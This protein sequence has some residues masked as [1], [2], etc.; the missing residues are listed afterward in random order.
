MYCKGCGK[1]ISE[2]SVFCN[3]CGTRQVPQK[4]IIEFTKPS[5]R[6]N[7]NLLRFWIFRVIKFTKSAFLFLVPLLI[8]LLLWGIAAL[9]VW[10]GVYYIF[11]EINRPPVE[12]LQSIQNFEKHGLVP[13]KR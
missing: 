11:Q 8:R 9:V 4:I 2:D 6:W 5:F 12:S 13:M 10:W 1:E 7:G 3:Y